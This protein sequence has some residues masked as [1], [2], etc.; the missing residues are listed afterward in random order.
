MGSRGRR[1]GRRRWHA[2]GSR[3]LLAA[4]GRGLLE[5]GFGSGRHQRARRLWGAS[6]AVAAVV[7]RGPLTGRRGGC[8]ICGSAPRAGAW[9]RAHGTMGSRVSHC[10]AGGVGALLSPGEPGP[11]AAPQATPAAPARSCPPSD[12]ARGR[13][14]GGAHSLWPQQRFRGAGAVVQGGR[15]DALVDAPRREPQSLVPEARGARGGG[16]RSQ[17]V[18][19]SHVE[20]ISVTAV[21]D[22]SA[23]G[24]RR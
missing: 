3:G 24:R 11:L 15:P 4:D 12:T 8:G 16:G 7:A 22:P 2:T 10:E 6:L 14:L 5:G 19:S 1:A 23:V 20:R 9:Y 13:A 17:M 21:P 18:A